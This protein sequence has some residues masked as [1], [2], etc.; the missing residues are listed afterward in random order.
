MKTVTTDD[1]FTHPRF[2]SGVS[3]NY[4]D[5]EISIEYRDQSCDL[6]INAAKTELIDLL[7]SLGV[8]G[9]TVNELKQ[10]YLNLSSSIDSLIEEFDRLGL[11]TETE[12]SVNADCISGHEFYYQIRAFADSCI[13]AKCRSALYEGLKKKT[14]NREALIGYVLEYFYLVRQ[15]PGLIAPSLSHAE[16]MHVQKLLQG[17]LASELNHDE[18]LAHSLEAVGIRSNRLELMQPLPA[19]FSLCA[20]L[21]VYAKQHPLTFKSLLFLFEMPSIAFNEVLVEY[22]KSEGMPEKFWEPL[23][24]HATINDELDHEDITLT[25]LKEIEAISPEEQIVTKKHVMIAI[26]TMALQEKQIIDYYSS[27]NA[28]IPRLFV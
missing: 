12:F 2:R 16:P 19:T 25:L 5:N 20:S 18:M 4:S 13:Q 15:A 10:R 22:C 9:K 8:G 17:F 11:L 24:R 26:E 27:Q 21:G 23:L 1:I 6:E 3:V 28:I 7:Q 14:L